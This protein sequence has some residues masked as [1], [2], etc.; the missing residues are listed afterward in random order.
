M[1]VRKKKNKTVPIWQSRQPP[2]PKQPQKLRAKDA[3]I[4]EIAELEALLPEPIRE[5]RAALRQRRYV[6]RRRAR[7]QQPPEVAGSTSR[8]I[9][10][11]QWAPSAP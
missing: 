11:Q 8:A 10:A 1:K 2:Q 7:G 6:R 5:E 3:E 4:A 9:P